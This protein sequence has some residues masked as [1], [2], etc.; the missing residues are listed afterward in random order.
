MK[1]NKHNLFSLSTTTADA[2]ANR[3]LQH[4]VSSWKLHVPLGCCLHP[5]LLCPSPPPP[6]QAPLQRPPARVKCQHIAKT[7]LLL[8]A[9]VAPGRILQGEPVH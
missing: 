4:R 9:Q 8:A 3:L 6:Y 1:P 2:N 5:A 7:T